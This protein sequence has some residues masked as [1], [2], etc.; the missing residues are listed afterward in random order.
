MS[1]LSASLGRVLSLLTWV[2]IIDI[3]SGSHIEN[4]FL[5]KGVS[6]LTITI[7]FA[8]LIIYNLL[9][10]LRMLSPIPTKSINGTPAVE[11][12]AYS[13]EL[14]NKSQK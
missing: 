5:S 6:P 1:V 8:M 9:G 10:I 3:I 14:S 4:Y 7:F 12:L 2:A 13:H 11:I